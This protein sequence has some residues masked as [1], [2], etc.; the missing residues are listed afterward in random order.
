LVPFTL[1]RIAF[2]ARSKPATSSQPHDANAANAHADF[3]ERVSLVADSLR[4]RCRY[5]IH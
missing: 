4:Q 5:G 2:S 3:R 1:W